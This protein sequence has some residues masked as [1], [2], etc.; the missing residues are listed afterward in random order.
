MIPIVTVRTAALEDHTDVARL[1]SAST[2]HLVKRDYPADVVES[3]IQSG[4]LGL[5]AQLIEDGTYYLVFVSGELVAAGGWSFRKTLF[6]T[7]RHFC[8]VG[9][10]LEPAIEPARIRGFYVHP[11]FVGRGFGS[12]LL[13]TCESAA[14]MAGFQSLELAA[15]PSGERLYRA[16]GYIGSRTIECD[17]GNGLI[18][19]GLLMAK[20]F[21]GSETLDPLVPPNSTKVP[22]AHN[23][24]AA[25]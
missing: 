1:I 7:G 25:A 2:Q 4:A 5:D 23:P 21:S 11:G 10:D 12:L 6:G 16:N 22:T 18:M 20:R 3:A 14:R 24:T 19:Q 15:T 8:E 9:C 13:R 17:V